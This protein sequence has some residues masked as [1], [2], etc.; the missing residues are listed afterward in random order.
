M[1]APSKSGI[2]FLANK[3]KKEERLGNAPIGRI[4][5]PI[6][7]KDMPTKAIIVTTAG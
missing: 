6:E 4:P 5:T 1:I 3:G 7:T 2:Y